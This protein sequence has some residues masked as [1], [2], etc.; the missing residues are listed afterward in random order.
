MTEDIKQ[1]LDTIVQERLEFYYDRMEK[2][3][4]GESLRR[5]KLDI[6]FENI[7]A[8][9]PP[10]QAEIIRAHEDVIISLGAEQEHEAYLGGVR[11]GV[12]LSR[13]LKEL[14]K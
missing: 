3:S 11:D 2:C 5:K 9:L 7:L 10:E 14:L 4:E 1:L 13:G 12:Q 8:S 6:A